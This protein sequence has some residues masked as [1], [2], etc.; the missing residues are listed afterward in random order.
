[1]PRR[2][3]SSSHR[4]VLF[5]HGKVC[6]HNSIN[7]MQNRISHIMVIDIFLLRFVWH[8]LGSRTEDFE[9]P[10]L[11]RNSEAFEARKNIAFSGMWKHRMPVSVFKSNGCVSMRNCSDFLCIIIC[12]IVWTIHSLQYPRDRV[13]FP[14]GNR[15]NFEIWAVPRFVYMFIFLDGRD[16]GIISMFLWVFQN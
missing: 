10:K 14:S 4:F 15:I 9:P 13:P 7:I 8:C 11:L 12:L 16:S 3:P 6:T 5:F 2:T 1:M